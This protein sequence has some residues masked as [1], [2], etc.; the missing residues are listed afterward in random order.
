MSARTMK[1][2]NNWAQMVVYSPMALRRRVMRRLVASVYRYCEG[3]L[4]NLDGAAPV[5]GRPVWRG[6]YHLP[7]RGAGAARL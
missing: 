7:E 3:H 5:Q 1:G 6:L 4:H 2:H